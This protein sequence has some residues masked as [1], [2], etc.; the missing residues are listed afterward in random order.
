[1]NRG[2]K[3]KL[4]V[5]GQR[6]RASGE[7]GNSKRFAK[8]LMPDGRVAKIPAAKDAST[9]ICLANE[10]GSWPRKATTTL[11]YDAVWLVEGVV[12]GLEEMRPGKGMGTIRPVRVVASFPIIQE[13]EGC[14]GQVQRWL[15]CEETVWG[16][17]LDGM[18]PFDIKGIR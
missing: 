10:D 16:A 5:T 11:M 2:K 3:E 6:R 18:S 4:A 8:V 9:Y 12:F 14:Y 7:G 15:L 17:E 13:H 1:M